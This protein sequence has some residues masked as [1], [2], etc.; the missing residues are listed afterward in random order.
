MASLARLKRIRRTQPRQ[1]LHSVTEALHS[2]SQP[3]SSPRSLPRQ[4]NPPQR[5]LQ[6]SAQGSCLIL[7]EEKILL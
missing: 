7:T 2:L 6:K 4:E 5:S 1:C 3:P